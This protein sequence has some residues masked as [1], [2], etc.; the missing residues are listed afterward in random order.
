[1]ARITRNPHCDTNTAAAVNTARGECRCAAGHKELASAVWL[2]KCCARD[3]HL[4]LEQPR[5]LCCFMLFMDS[6]FSA[7]YWN[8]LFI[9]VNFD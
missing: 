5:V 6:L 2:T 4:L 1:M 3:T 7:D 8:S 9:F